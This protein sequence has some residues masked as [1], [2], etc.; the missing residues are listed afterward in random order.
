MENRSRT[1]LL[2]RLAWISTKMDQARIAAL[3]LPDGPPFDEKAAARRFA[4]EFDSATQEMVNGEPCVALNAGGIRDTAE[5]H[6]AISSIGRA[7]AVAEPD[8]A[9]VAKGILGGG[10]AASVPEACPRIVR[11]L[12]DTVVAEHLGERAL[13]GALREAAGLGPPAAVPTEEGPA[14]KKP[15]QAKAPNT[16]AV[17]GAIEALTQADVDCAGTGGVEA[18]LAQANAWANTEKKDAS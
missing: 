11:S 3:L 15:R 10:S 6:M 9:E 4:E 8:V 14:S 17:L 16:D 13:D 1:S 12:Q 5:S 7:R 2:P 18:L